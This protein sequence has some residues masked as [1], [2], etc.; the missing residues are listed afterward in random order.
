M[1]VLLA[2]KDEMDLSSALLGM[3]AVM[4]LGADGSAYQK[5]D[6]DSSGSCDATSG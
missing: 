1:V 3:V 5:T 2:K 6:R 4:M